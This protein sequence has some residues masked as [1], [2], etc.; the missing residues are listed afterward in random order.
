MRGI[1][2]QLAEKIDKRIV[3]CETLSEAAMWDC[4]D[5]TVV[6]RSGRFT[7][8]PHFYSVYRLGDHYSF[9]LLALIV[10]KVLQGGRLEL[11][12]DALAAARRPGFMLYDGERALDRQIVRVGAPH[13]CGGSIRNV[14]DYAKRIATALR[15]DTAAVEA[16]NPGKTNLILCGGKDSLNL[17]LLPWKQPTKAVSAEPNYPLVAEFVHRNDLPME[18]I[19]L[20]DPYDAEHLRREILEACMRVDVRYWRWGAHLVRLAAGHGGQVV[21]WKGQAGDLYMTDKWK[22]FHHPPRKLEEYARKLYKRLPSPFVVR[23]A[24]GR[25]LQPRV[26]RATWDR[27]ALLQGCHMAFIRALTDALA[28]SAYHG[29][30]MIQVWSEADLGSV[31]QEDMRGRVGKLLADRDVV[32]PRENPAPG[33]SMFRAGLSSPDRFLELLRKDDLPYEGD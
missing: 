7:G 16:C 26:I 2:Q 19:R 20:E 31:A 6:W 17:L 32:Y 28:L 12:P 1:L 30:R 5:G 27:C 25:R 11:N 4:H 10:W 9:S 13:G 24:V 8:V 22:T 29:P 33:P 21:F 18:V 23:R 3:E 14:D 15:E